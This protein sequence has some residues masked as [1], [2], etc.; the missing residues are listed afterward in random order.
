MPISMTCVISW[1][2][3]RTGRISRTSWRSWMPR[4]STPLPCPEAIVYLT[5]GIL[6]YL[7]NEAELAGVMGHELGHI[8]ARH[9]AQQYSRAQLAQF[10]VLVGGL[11]LGD[12]VSGRRSARGRNAFPQFQQGQR[13]AGRS[14]WAWSTRAR[15]A[16]TA[17]N[18]PRFLK[19]WSA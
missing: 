7:N 13:E 4:S 1:R 14:S 2:G 6:A 15:Q 9:S 17:K 19:P 3:F 11:F 12:L 16:M 5:R 18:W 10:G 8:T